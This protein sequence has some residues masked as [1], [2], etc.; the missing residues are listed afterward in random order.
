MIIS[1]QSN[2]TLS[3]H[4]YVAEN[5]GLDGPSR[6]FYLTLLCIP[7]YS[8]VGFNTGKARTNLLISINVVVCFT[9]LK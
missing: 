8:G 6:A 7:T 3:V 1:A 4:T 2:Y 9:L 5:K